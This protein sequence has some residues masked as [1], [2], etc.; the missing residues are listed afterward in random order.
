MWTTA[1]SM[2]AGGADTP[3]RAAP[4]S[5]DTARRPAEEP[6]LPFGLVVVFR[7]PTQ[8]APQGVDGRREPAE[9]PDARRRRQSS[10]SERDGR[11]LVLAYGLHRR[12][13]PLP[14]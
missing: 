12:I 2:K 3:S 1:Y 11:R 5:V 4:A 8:G 9:A 10:A 14:A 7:D 6:G 13:P